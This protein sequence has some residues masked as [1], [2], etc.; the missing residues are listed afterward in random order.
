[1]RDKPAIALGLARAFYLISNQLMAEILDSLF[2]KN[3]NLVRARVKS[4]GGK[5]NTNY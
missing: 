2:L 4:K 3:V 5:W 1:M